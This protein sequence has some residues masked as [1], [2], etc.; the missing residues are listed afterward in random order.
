MQVMCTR[1]R[2]VAAWLS[3]ALIL[4]AV[5]SHFFATVSYRYTPHSAPGDHEHLQQQL[6]PSEQSNSTPLLLDD[7]T[8][9]TPQPICYVTVVV[10]VVGSL[11]LIHI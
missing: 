9:P 2:V 1:R 4:A 3:T 6:S 11:S 8:A 5:S 7:V 10:V